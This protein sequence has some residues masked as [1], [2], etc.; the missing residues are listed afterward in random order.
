[1]NQEHAGVVATP[2]AQETLEKWRRRVRGLPAVIWGRWVLRHA[3]SVG[4]WTRVSG[5]PKINNHGTMII[6]SKVQI[7][8]SPIRSELACL[9][10]GRLEIGA[11]T[12]INYGTSIGASSLIRIGRNCQ[13]GNHCIMIDNDYHG[14]DLALRT[15][16][17]PSQPIILGDNVWLGVRVTVL[18]GV[19]IGDGAVIGAGSVVTHDIPA[20]AVAAGVPARILRTF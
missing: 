9:S 4:I 12:F 8:S 5:W 17:P 13:I 19:Q 1:M 7:A 14:I 11:G 20:R 10:G 3:T 18:K 16:M 2:D 6:G 15:T